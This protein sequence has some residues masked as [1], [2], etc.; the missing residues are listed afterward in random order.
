[1]KLVLCV[2]DRGGLA[3]N[4][5]RQSQDRAVRA[6]MLQMCGD[7]KLWVST[8]TAQQFGDSEQAYLMISETGFE[9]VPL[10]TFCFMEDIEPEPYIDSANEIVLYHW[11]RLYPADR[12]LKLPLAQWDC[13]ECTEFPGYSHE[14]ITKEVYTR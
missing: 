5:R 2:D 12:K 3:F 1:M 9:H 11:N 7:T 14:K 6:D 13:V 10:E 4:H 8:Y